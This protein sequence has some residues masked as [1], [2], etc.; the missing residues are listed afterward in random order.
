[1]V[2][3]ENRIAR[4]EAEASGRSSPERQFFTNE[5]LNETPTQQRRQ[6]D[7]VDEVEG[8]A[9]QH[10]APRGERADSSSRAS[11]IS[12][13]TTRRNVA[14]RI[15]AIARSAHDA[16]ILKLRVIVSA[17]AAGDRVRRHEG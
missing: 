6:C 1:M 3:A 15:A 7:D 9:E 13:S 5:M 2:S 10:G 8:E 14:V 11:T 17:L 16:A 4:A 12:R